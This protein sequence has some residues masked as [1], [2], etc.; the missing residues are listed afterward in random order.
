[1]HLRSHWSCL[2]ELYV[3]IYMSVSMTVPTQNAASPESTKSKSRNSNFLTIS[4]YRFKLRFW[5]N[6]NLYRGIWVSRFWGFWGCS[7]FSR[8]CHV[9]CCHVWRCHVWRWLLLRFPRNAI[10]KW[11]CKSSQDS[12]PRMLVLSV[13]DVCI[14]IHV[15]MYMKLTPV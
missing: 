2:Y 6:L 1:M 9:W 15:C 7:I 8:R 5:F 11:A 3:F 4:R 14:Y 12:H 10:T 13:W